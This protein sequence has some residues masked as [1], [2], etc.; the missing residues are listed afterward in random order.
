MCVCIYI[1]MYFLG[2]QPQ[3]MEVPR[4][5]V[6][7]ELQLPACATAAALWDSSRMGKLYRNS[8]QHQIL[9]GFSE[10]G[11]GTHIFMDASQVCFL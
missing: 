10:A 6:Q 8:Q 7:S 11:D 5:G 9:N 3:H 2:L 4:L 1:Y